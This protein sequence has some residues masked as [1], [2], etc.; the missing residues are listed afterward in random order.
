[1][2]LLHDLIYLLTQ[3]FSNYLKQYGMTCT[4]FQLQGTSVYNEESENCLSCFWLCWGFTTCQP[5]W[6]ILCSLPEK[7][8]KEIEEIAE[9]MKKGDREERGTGMKEKK[10][11]NKNI[12]P[13]P[14]PATR[15][16]SQYQLDARVTQDIR[17]LCH[18]RPPPHV[19]HLQVLIKIF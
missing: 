12:P 13:L 14:L 1:M 5:L 16:V 18:T 2:T 4:I 3:H 7:G 8:R 9:E 15:T 6:V 19:T 10:L 11:R 17:H